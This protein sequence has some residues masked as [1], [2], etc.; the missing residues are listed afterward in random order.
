MSHYP[1]SFSAGGDSGA[2]SIVGTGMD[3]EKQFPLQND[4]H[5]TSAMTTLQHFESLYHHA[6]QIA[7]RRQMMALG[8]SKH[9]RARVNPAPTPKPIPDP[10]L[11][12]HPY[13]VCSRHERARVTGEQAGRSGSR[14]QFSLASMFTHSDLTFHGFFVHAS[15]LVIH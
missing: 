4:R 7:P 3:R 6:C 12:P 13:L 8:C 11:N 14:L 15:I 2:K 5:S 1:P 10:N 9:D